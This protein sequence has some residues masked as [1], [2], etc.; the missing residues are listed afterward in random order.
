MEDERGVGGEDA[1]YTRSKCPC[2]LHGQSEKLPSIYRWSLKPR[3]RVRSSRER[4]RERASEQGSTSRLER[5][6]C[7]GRSGLGGA[8]KTAEGGGSLARIPALW[9]RRR[10]GP[11]CPSGRRARH[12]LRAVQEMDGEAVVAGRG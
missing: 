3:R 10:A 6:G 9:I 7:E 1:L 2:R 12:V 4:A 11:A 8:G 5:P